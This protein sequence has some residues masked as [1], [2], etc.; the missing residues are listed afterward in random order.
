[1]KYYTELSDFT[2]EN[3][4]D[5][6]NLQELLENLQLELDDLIPD[7]SQEYESLYKDL[8][9]QI[10]VL[11]D[12]LTEVNLYESLIRDSY[13]NDYLYELVHDIGDLPDNL[14]S[15]IKSNIDWDGVCNDL[16]YDYSIVEIDGVEYWQR[17][18]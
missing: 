15:Y 13:M 5:P 11:T 6:N 4:I 14:P 7:D 18:G 8:N 3:I 12:I 1:M 9:D 10:N 2:S 17:A 16:K